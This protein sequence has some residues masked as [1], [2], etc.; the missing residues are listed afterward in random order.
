MNKFFAFSSAIHR[1]PS[2]TFSS[3]CFNSF[4]LVDKALTSQ[5]KM[6]RRVHDNTVA[7]CFR[8]SLWWVGGERGENEFETLT[9]TQCEV[10]KKFRIKKIVFRKKIGRVTTLFSCWR[11]AC[12]MLRMYHMNVS[13]K[14]TGT[15]VC[16][17]KYLWYES[18]SYSLV[19]KITIPIKNTSKNRRN[20]K[21]EAK[22]TSKQ[23]IN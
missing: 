20:N 1:I 2:F 5:V 15:L 17:M 7:G 21:K 13:S 12:W 19:L 14:T 23:E 4:T 9:E 3:C 8:M 18:N 6:N 10:A 11:P 22:A 16:E